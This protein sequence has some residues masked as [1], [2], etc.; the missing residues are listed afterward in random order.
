MK[1][2][3]VIILLGVIILLSSASIGY[4]YLA[5]YTIQQWTV[6]AGGGTSISDQ[7]SLSGT[8]GQTDAGMLSGGD[9]SLAGGFWGGGWL[10][11]RQFFLPIITR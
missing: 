2:R 6:D 9:Y 4:A 5:D 1:T 7:Y 3:P 10:P 11:E 8:I